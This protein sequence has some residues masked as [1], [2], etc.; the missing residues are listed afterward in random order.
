M[1]RVRRIVLIMMATSLVTIGARGGQ[2]PTQPVGRGQVP[3]SPTAQPLQRVAFG[4]CASQELP[5]PIWNAIGAARPELFIL[6]GDNIYG[7][8]EDMDIM[9]AKYAK[10]A[11]MPG[12][13]ALREQCRLLAT[14]DDHDLGVNDGGSEYPKKVE[15]QQVF[16]D[17]FGDPPQSPRR[18]RLGVYDA[19]VFGPPGQRVQV[20]LLDT[21]YFRTPLKARAVLTRGQSPYEASLDPAAT[22]LGND[23]WRWLA[24]QLKVPAEIRLIGSSVQVVAEDHGWEKWMNFPRERERLFE[25]IRQAGAEGVIFLSGDRHLGELSMMDTGI[26]YPIYDLTS[27]G[28]NQGSKIWQPLE[29]NRHRVATM[30]W[31]DNF[32]FITIDW[33]PTDPKISLQIRDVEG[34]IIVQ[35]K[36]SLSNLRR[37]GSKANAVKP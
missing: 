37:R 1:Q 28:L 32:G 14:W 34:D 12:F 16:L 7:D 30:S 26:G 20:I 19:H 25:L 13:K 36:L 17:F 23:Q 3:V 35:Q 9:R 24:E 22:M 6:L 5:Q 29:T 11:A 4:S 27:S 8:T 18:R 33:K 21:R 10:L 31:G 2:V 15:S